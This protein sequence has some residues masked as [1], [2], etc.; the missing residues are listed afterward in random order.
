MK[1]ARRGL[2]V[3][4]ADR[5]PEPLLAAP[6]RVFLNVAVALIGAAAFWPPV[7]SVIT[8]NWYNEVRWSWGGIMVLAGL[9]SLH[10]MFRDDP[11]TERTGALALLV[12][13]WMY[14]TT[15]A[16]VNGWGG[17]VPILIFYG[18]GVAKLIRLIRST[19]YAQTR[20][21]SLHA[22]DEQQGGQGPGAD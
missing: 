14:A 11:V 9:F 3:R 2:A 21:A 22:L 5:L 17:I 20:R 15:L 19:A 12:G 4:I 16:V 10:G 7:G 13:S 1:P 8:D 18:I 6:E